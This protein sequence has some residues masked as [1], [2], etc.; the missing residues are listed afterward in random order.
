MRVLLIGHSYVRDIMHL[1]YIIPIFQSGAKYYTYFDNPSLLDTADYCH[2]D[3]IVVI[4]A[5]NCIN[6][7]TASSELYQKARDFYSMLRDRLPGAKII[8]AQ[9]WTHS[10]QQVIIAWNAP[11]ENEYSNRRNAFFYFLKRNKNKDAIMEISGPGRMDNK[12]YYSDPL[13]QKF[14]VVATLRMIGIHRSSVDGNRRPS[15]AFHH[16]QCRKCRFPDVVPRRKCQ[17]FSALKSS[18][19][20]LKPTLFPLTN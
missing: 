19:F 9:A 10:M 12:E 5:G 18:D 4:L 11:A 20:R 1:G 6:N 7:Y 17:W 16:F 15:S 14:I 3:Y 13:N 8:T 2:P